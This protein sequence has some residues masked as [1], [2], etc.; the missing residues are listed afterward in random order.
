M[1]KKLLAL[2]VL[3][4]M[5]ILTLTIS[6]PASAA[7]VWD[8]SIATGFATGTGTKNNPYIILNASQL[9]YLTLETN[10]GTTFEGQYIKLM[11]DVLIN[12]ETFKKDP[13]T[14]E[15]TDL[16]SDTL[17]RWVPIGNATNPFKG[18]FD[19]NG[20]VIYGLYVDTASAYAGLFGYVSGGSVKNISVDSSYINTTSTS[21]S[22]CYTAGIAGYSNGVIENCNYNGYVFSD[23]AVS[24]PHGYVGGIVGLN[25]GRVKNCHNAGN[26]SSSVSSSFNSAAYSGS[27]DSY[28]G[29][30]AGYSNAGTI[31]DC[32]NTGDI[33]SSTS[34]SR[35]YAYAGG[36]VAY[37]YTGT[38]TNCYNTGNINSS[39]TS[40]IASAGGILGEDSDGCTIVNC[41]NSGDVC[42]SSVTSSS[43]AGGICSGENKR[44]TIEKCYNTG[45]ISSSSKGSDSC[46][47][48]GG[49]TSI[50]WGVVD[51]CYNTG[52]VSSDYSYV[53]PTSYDRAYAG[54]IAG[55]SGGA[56]LG[57]TIT[58]CYNTGDVDCS[59]KFSSSYAGGIA[60]YRDDYNIEN[61]YNTGKISSYSSVSSSAYVGGI[62]GKNNNKG[63]IKNCYY[64]NNVT[65]GI[66]G[67]SND[68]TS[69]CTESQ[70]TRQATYFGFD[71]QNVWTFSG[72]PCYPYAELKSVNTVSDHYYNY[73][74]CIVSCNCG[75]VNPDFG[76]TEVIDKKVEA[77]CTESGLTQGKHCLICTEI[78]VAQEVVPPKGHL[79]GSWATTTAPTCTVSG[80]ERRAC[81]AC[82]YYETRPINTLDHTEVIDT[83]VDA[84]CTASGLTEGEHCSVCNK[85]LVPQQ[86]IDALGHD[87]ADEWTV[88]IES[89]TTT[90]GSM[91]RHCSRCDEITDIIVIAK[92]VEIIDSSKKFCD[93]FA[94]SWAKP[95]IDY[96]VSYGYMNGTGDGSTFSPTGTMTR[97]MIVSV[98][99]RIAGKPVS[100]V[101]NP[102]TDLQANQT[103]YHE[104]VVW[105]YEN[106]IVTGTSAT[107]F[108][109]TGAV[110]R[111]QMATFLYRFA[112]YIGV[113]VSKKADLSTFPDNGDVGA[114]AT[115]ALAWA[116]AEGLINGA[117]N[118]DVI[119][120][121]PKG[122]AT[123][124]QVATILMRFC[125]TYKE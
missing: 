105:A 51:S 79:L 35:S 45:S 92:K 26:I 103:W 25:E 118:G 38:I 85:V 4:A 99:Y 18:H 91:S 65:N 107:T 95:G 81:N 49:I 34:G 46:V 71:F 17:D 90:T 70:L 63:T 10:N 24:F 3:A 55:D 101:D 44:G 113:N 114:W 104:A 47:Y 84:T 39:S 75:Y 41:N 16:Y 43:Y 61:C 97:A 80:T 21:T 123:R 109:P 110:T 64:V 53:Y 6:V 54:G 20:H 19:G 66:G 111:E 89:T 77:T 58:N 42:A 100:T 40:S 98:L 11:C 30:I 108:A 22:S 13:T 125:Q 1:K 86:T 106:G 76:H 102:F 7:D 121:N 87:F 94:K 36:I 56:N 120:L 27:Y 32:Y 33:S 119:L 59:S 93:V 112:K 82:D 2:L 28:A 68:T 31:T 48:A 88:D 5:M 122:A 72:N 74:G 57:G 8:G 52:K 29:G 117:K 115:E 78:L 9:M 73:N 37:D 12:D 67:T 62:V 15:I 83:E 69:K 60:G 50:N 14:G 124:E 23:I 116:N 96:V